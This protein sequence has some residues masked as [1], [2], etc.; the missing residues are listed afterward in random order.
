MHAFE[1]ITLSSDQLNDITKY[2]SSFGKEWV[3]AAVLWAKAEAYIKTT[4]FRI[5]AESIY[6]PFHERKDVYSRIDNLPI[7]QDDLY[8]LHYVNGKV[9]GKPGDMKAIQEWTC[10]Q[11]N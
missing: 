8:A 11:G 6:K 1:K 2:E 5:D 7:T 4:L 9:I 10:D 3:A